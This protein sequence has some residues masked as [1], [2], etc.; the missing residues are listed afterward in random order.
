MKKIALGTCVLAAGLVTVAHAREFRPMGYE[1]IAMGGA[2]VASAK[3]AMAAYYNP[4]LLGRNTSKSE[5]VTTA[6]IGE[7]EHN[8][9]DNL[10]SLSDAG[11]SDA[12][13]R[14]AAN[15]PLGTN[16]AA[17]Q[18]SLINSQN[19]LAS[20]AGGKNGF[21]LMPDVAFGFQ[22]Q[23][24]GFGVY[25]ISEGT[26]AAVVDPDHLAFSVQNGAN[27]YAYDPVN[28]TYSVI[29][30]ATY[31]ASSLEYA[32][33]N[34]LT[35]VQLNGLE[36]VEYP[37]SY[38]HPF[39]LGAGMLSMGAT[40]KLM[41]A[42]TYNT[43]IKVDTPSRDIEDLLENSEKDDDA[44]SVDAGL[45]FIP[46][47]AKNLTLG[48]VGKYLNSP[49][50][51][52]VVPGEN[53]QIK[54]Q[55][56]AGLNFAANERMSFALDYDLSRNETFIPDVD[57]QYLGGGFNYRP[58]SWFSFRVGAMKNVASSAEGA[59]LTAGVGFGLDWLQV[60]LGVQRSNRKGSLDGESIP[61][62]ARAQIAIVSRW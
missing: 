58:L 50:F 20:M 39:Q 7:R 13:A 24:L 18:Q 43:H 4:A 41:D 28:D 49:D 44:V 56:R 54:P 59:I 15:A 12:L 6:G 55:F 34:D 61:R 27:Y 5:V 9:A 11:F 30:Q 35:Y 16:T 51:K 22:T 17:D 10:D 37:V 46:S 1:S 31:E 14:V 8:L 29:T 21:S 45:L 42:T 3:G 60:D 19:I 48:L 25:G 32:V 53:Y 33:N 36:I 23:R 47:G 40:L 62:Y 26:A 2:G 57:A 52:T 38:G